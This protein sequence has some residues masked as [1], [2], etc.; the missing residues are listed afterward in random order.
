MR[1]HFP[2]TLI[3]ICNFNSSKILSFVKEMNGLYYCRMSPL[4]VQTLVPLFNLPTH[5]QP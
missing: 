5:Y 2:H 1:A 3:S 4:Q